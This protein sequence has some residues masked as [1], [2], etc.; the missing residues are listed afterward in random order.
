MEI[1]GKKNKNKLHKGNKQYGEIN[2]KKK[3]VVTLE[4][5]F[6]SFSRDKQT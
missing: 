4:H 5:Y 2:Y 3:V 1:I 6:H